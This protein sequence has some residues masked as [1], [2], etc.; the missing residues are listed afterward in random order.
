MACLRQAVVVS[1]LGFWGCRH[2][3]ETWIVEGLPEDF[4]G[5]KCMQPDA[6]LLGRMT[7]WV[8]SVST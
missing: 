1:L 7:G 8:G 3:K 2:L 6:R 4:A 5:I